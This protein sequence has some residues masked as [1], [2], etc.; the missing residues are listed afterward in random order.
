M[1]KSANPDIRERFGFAVKSRREELELTQEDLADNA[2]ELVDLG[3]ELYSRLGT[4]TE[5]VPKLGRSIERTVA[6]YNQ[7]N[8]TL[9]PR[10]PATDQTLA[11]VRQAKPPDRAPRVRGRFPTLPPRARGPGAPRYGH[12]A[13]IPTG[14]AVH[15]S[16]PA[17]AAEHCARR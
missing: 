5:H 12:P 15:R 4:L 17:R 16:A 14:S 6:G 11:R 13:E 2:Q 10:F 1:K 8:G 7:F 3:R 9:A